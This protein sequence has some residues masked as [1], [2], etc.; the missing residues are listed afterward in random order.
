LK[1]CPCRFPDQRK[2]AGNHSD[3]ALVLRSCWVRSLSVCH[4]GCTGFVPDDLRFT[5]VPMITAASAGFTPPLA[6]RSSRPGGRFPGGRRSRRRRH[7]PTA[8]APIQPSKP[9]T[10]CTATGGDHQW[11]ATSHPA[12]GSAPAPHSKPP[13][14]HRAGS[15]PVAEMSDLP[16]TGD[17][18]ESGS[19][20]AVSLRS[21]STFSQVG[22]LS[23]RPVWTATPKRARPGS[24]C[25]R[26]R[27]PC[28][29]T[30]AARDR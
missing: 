30:P 15:T 5:G 12:A 19:R 23:T 24:R 29:A 10:E 7:S 22:S 17:L 20:P 25:L 14:N 6:E 16:T 4:L 28:W 27:G 1:Y 18:A 9:G 2:R 11:P 3:Q 21:A 8:T 26:A 13:D